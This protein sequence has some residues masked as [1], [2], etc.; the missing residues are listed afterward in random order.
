MIIKK[1]KESPLK[2]VKQNSTAET[3]IMQNLLEMNRKVG[4]SLKNRNKL[5]TFNSWNCDNAEL[6][7]NYKWL[8]KVQNH[9][10]IGR[11][12]RND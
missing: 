10:K 7:H 11:L 12:I 3:V 4:N 8:E 6:I 2:R 5:Y 9:L 1:E